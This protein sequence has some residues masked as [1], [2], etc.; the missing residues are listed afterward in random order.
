MVLFDVTNKRGRFLFSQ[1]TGT[2]DV[3]SFVLE[4]VLA[5]YDSAKHFLK[6]KVSNLDRDQVLFV[7]EGMRFLFYSFLFFSDEP[8][9]QDFFNRAKLMVASRKVQEK[10]QS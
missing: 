5:A 10:Q 9:I 6:G 4:E 7:N 1:S 2:V 3:F 8:V